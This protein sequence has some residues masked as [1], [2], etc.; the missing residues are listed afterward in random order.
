MARLAGERAVEIDYMELAAALRGPVLRLGRRV[1][2]V[3][4]HVV[5]PPLAQPDAFAV[6]QVDGWQDDHRHENR[7]ENQPSCVDL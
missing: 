3:H 7:P 4:G 2:A 5:S 1:V 6:L